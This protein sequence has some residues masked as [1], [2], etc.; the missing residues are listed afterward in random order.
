LQHTKKGNQFLK[1]ETS[2]KNAIRKLGYKITKLQKNPLFDSDDSFDGINHFAGS[3]NSKGIYFDVGANVGQTVARFKNRLPPG[4]IYA[5][6]PGNTY[7]ELFRRHNGENNIILENIAFGAK[8]EQKQFYVNSHLDMSSF[9]PLGKL[10][11]GEITDEVLINV[12]TI[13][14]YCQDK[15][16][17]Y[18][19]LLKSDTQGF[20][21]EVLLGASS[22]LK[23]THLVYLEI[24]FR[25]IYK[26]DPGFNEI[27]KFLTSKGFK[28]VR[29]YEQAYGGIELMHADGLFVN[30][31]F[32]L[33]NY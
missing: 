27:Y 10:G 30:Q 24:N 2:L 16:I 6:E 29:F 8:N 5:F 4:K 28:F 15:N 33:N 32:N 11:W 9:L 23:N 1:Y 12:K 19:N 20:D 3:M 26:N 25:E 17:K 14:D 31:D 22:M 18:I 21:L 13:D 7:N